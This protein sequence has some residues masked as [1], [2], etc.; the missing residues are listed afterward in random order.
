MRAGVQ[1]ETDDDIDS[2][3]MGLKLGEFFDFA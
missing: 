3:V 1:F 2:S